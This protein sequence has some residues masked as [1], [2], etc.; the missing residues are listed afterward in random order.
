[1]SKSNHKT[2]PSLE[3]PSAEALL[4]KSLI[5]QKE[6]PALASWKT[7][8]VSSASDSLGV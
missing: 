6:S 8:G 2:D 5:P 4:E 1:M 3:A 7:Y